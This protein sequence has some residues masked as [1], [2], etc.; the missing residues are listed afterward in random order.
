VIETISELRNQEGKDIWLV[1]GGKLISMSL[2]AGLIDQML[3]I[4]LLV[5]LD[6]GIP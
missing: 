6:K 1:A 2:A 4:Y 5:V 3:I